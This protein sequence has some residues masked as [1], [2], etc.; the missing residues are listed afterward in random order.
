MNTFSLI[1]ICSQMYSVFFE[2]G[3]MRRMFTVLNLDTT[4]RE[5]PFYTSLLLNI[6]KLV[7]YVGLKPP[8]NRLFLVLE[9][10]RMCKCYLPIV[11]FSPER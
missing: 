6:G 7:Q 1:I 3:R 11:F 8:I 2:E 4:L 10:G 5:L 9:R